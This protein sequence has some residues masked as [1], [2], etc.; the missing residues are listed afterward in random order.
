MIFFVTLPGGLV[1]CVSGQYRVFP[2]L[3]AIIPLVVEAYLLQGAEGV[4]QGSA[5]IYPAG[6]GEAQQDS[7]ADCP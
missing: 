1:L 6:P 5:P 3:A 4:V 7:K 2:P